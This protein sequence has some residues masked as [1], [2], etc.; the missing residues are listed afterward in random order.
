[1]IIAIIYAYA[2]KGGV[3]LSSHIMRSKS[4][5]NCGI[6]LCQTPNTNVFNDDAASS[7]Q[8]LTRRSFASLLP[9]SL[10]LKGNDATAASPL[11]AEEADNFK[12]RA[13]RALRPKPPKVLRTR[14]NLDFAVL[15]MRS[16]YNAVDS[17]DIVPM[18]QF[19][20]V[21]Q[22]EYQYY[23]N[24]LGPGAMQQ[25]DL[26]DPNYFDFISFAQYA[27]I[28]RELNDPAVIFEEQQPVDVGEG[29][30][31]QFDTVVVKRDSLVSKSQLAQR[32][33]DIVG[34]AILNKLI[35]KF[36]DTPSAI[37]KI[38]VNSRPDAATLLASVKQMVNLFV[39]NG[40]AFNATAS[41]SKTGTG[42]GDAAG[43]EFSVIATSPANLWS[44]QSLKTAKTL[45]SRVGY[46]VTKSSVS[47]SN[48]QEITIFTIT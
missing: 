48:N 14:L 2:T 33:T 1:M 45:I 35:E 44:G 42:L 9:F 3:A 23:A 37:P 6:S 43:T 27:T 10:L 46:S 18:Q 16:S 4:A 36:G 40:F 17:I 8:H 41:I 30:P 28:N 11:S 22:A 34:N 32:H 31:Q 24:S 15:L 38:E 19:Q 13:E 20:K 26:A 47:Y 25:G 39:V 21:R 12:A 29:Q 7:A 5:R